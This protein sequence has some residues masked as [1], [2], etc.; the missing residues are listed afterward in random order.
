MIA[1]IQRLR[2]LAV[3]V[4]NIYKQITSGR[5]GRRERDVWFKQPSEMQAYCSSADGIGDDHH[6]SA[7]AGLCGQRS[8]F[9][10]ELRIFSEWQRIKRQW[11]QSLTPC[12]DAVIYDKKCYIINED[13]FSIIFN[14][15]EVIKN[16]IKE[17]EQ[18]IRDMSFIGNID[19][20]MEFLTKSK[21]QRNAMA[22]VVMQKR[23]DK[24][25]KFAPQY[26]R[27]QIEAQAELS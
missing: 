12:V 11:R 2:L 14:F 23:L 4:F 8:Q 15:D 1:K 9:R 19:A 27:K 5:E 24:I 16:Q 3:A 13:N 21:R 6:L 20:F 7:A 25:K 18:K 26:I 17:N 22:K 10:L